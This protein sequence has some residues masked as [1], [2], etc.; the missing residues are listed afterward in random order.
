M[1]KYSQIMR[2]QTMVMHK[3]SDI[4]HNITLKKIPEL[5]DEKKLYRT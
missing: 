3:F 5:G 4:A 1:M 2:L